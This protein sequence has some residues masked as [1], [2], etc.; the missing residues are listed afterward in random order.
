MLFLSGSLSGKLIAV[1]LLNNCEE[2]HSIDL[3]DLLAYKLCYLLCI[4]T[5]FW[6]LRAPKSWSNYFFQRF[7]TYLQKSHFHHLKELFG[8]LLGLN[9]FIFFVNYFCLQNKVF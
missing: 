4:S 9:L 8:D 5:S 1:R 7:S 6:V 3:V 2:W